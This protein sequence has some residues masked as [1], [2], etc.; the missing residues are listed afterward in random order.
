MNRLIFHFLILLGISMLVISCKRVKPLPPEAST[1]DTVLRP[2]MSIINL[3]VRYR[4]SAVQNM[5]NEKIK[6]TFIKKWLAVSE[7]GDSVY[8]EVSREKEIELSRKDRTLFLSIP[9]LVKGKFK[10]RMLGIKIKNATPVE[11]DLVLH[12]ATNLHLDP[13][14]NLLPETTIERID[15][16][17]EPVIKVGPAKVNLRKHIEKVLSE[18]ETQIIGK[19]DSVLQGLL[20]TRQVVQKLWMD[21]Q[22]PIRIN[23]KGV[24]VWLKAYGE[25]LTGYLQDT[26]PDLISLSF[27]LKAYT[28]TIIEGDSIPPSNPKLPPF[29]RDGSGDDSLRIFVHSKIAFSKINEILNTELVGKKLEAQGFSTTIKKIRTYGTPTGVAVQVDVRG[30]VNGKVYLSGST[31]FDTL[32][33]ILGIKDFNFS[34]DSE[35]ALVNTASWLLSTTVVDMIR[36]KLQV[37]VRPFVMQLPD[38][39]MQG[40]EK[41]KSGEKIDINIDTLF[42]RPQTIITTR[43]NIQLIVKANGRASLGL[44]R[45]IFDKKK[46]RRT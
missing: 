44:E 36:D 31:Q 42:V 37:D 13:E 46:K 26:E 43:D 30:D 18:N 22:K 3:P 10:A 24:Q 20:K 16:N 2:P 35:N 33:Y 23:K 7:K 25:D 39:I 11:A 38:L 40:V 8:L 21:I 4:V 45:K 6:G 29:R 9:L 14:W 19:A 32:T 5:L 27:Q 17:K 1:L 15:W 41:G 28:E 12:L 34:V